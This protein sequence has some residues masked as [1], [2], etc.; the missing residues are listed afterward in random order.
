[1]PTIEPTLRREDSNLSLKSLSKLKA[2][3][4]RDGSSGKTSDMLSKAKAAATTKGAAA[5]A[6][7][8]GNVAIKQEV[9]S[10]LNTIKQVESSNLKIV[11][12]QTHS[13]ELLKDVSTENRWDWNCQLY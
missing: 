2:A 11:S 7:S 5:V 8:G 1:M 4:S 3:L 12:V 6:N 10:K 13:A 9:V